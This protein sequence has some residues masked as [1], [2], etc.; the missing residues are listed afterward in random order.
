VIEFAHAGHWLVQLL[1]VVPVLFVVAAIVW[2]KIQ[3]RRE[4]AAEAEAIPDPEGRD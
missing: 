1:Y 3:E 2:S 4:E